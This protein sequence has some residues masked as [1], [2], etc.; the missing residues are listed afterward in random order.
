MHEE[1]FGPLLAFQRA[2]SLRE[3]IELANATE[4]GL[5]A[6]IITGD[7]AVAQTFV[8]ESRTGLVNVNQ[9]TTGMAMNAPFGGYKAS[10]TA[11]F[12]EQAGP[13]MMEF[14]LT[15]KTVYLNSAS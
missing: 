5:S 15:E 6:S 10:S 14:Y 8:R 12:K 11:T 4:Y 3:A 2:E 13:S 7:L 1:V 9:P